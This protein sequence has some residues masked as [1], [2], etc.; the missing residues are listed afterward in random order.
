M[1]KQCKQGGHTLGVASVIA[2]LSEGDAIA[3]LRVVFAAPK[4][5]LRK[6]RQAAMSAVLML[7]LS[8]KMQQM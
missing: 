5:A 8:S 3:S 2:Q 6:Q 1:E 4:E 7:S